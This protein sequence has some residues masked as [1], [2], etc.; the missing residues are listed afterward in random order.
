MTNDG[1]MAT[2]W[3]RRA[4]LTAGVAAAAAVVTGD[5]PVRRATAG[6]LPAHWSDDLCESYAIN[7][8]SFYAT[9][10]YQY[11]DALFD[12][13]TDLGVRTVRERVT[14]GSSL[15]AQQQRAMLVRLAESGVRWHATVATLADWP[16]AAQATDDALKAFTQF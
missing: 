1:L 9:S 12:L 8:K 15:G 16:R 13:I 10:V 7:T 2:A 5:A 3:S 11:A 4:V 6:G 14:T